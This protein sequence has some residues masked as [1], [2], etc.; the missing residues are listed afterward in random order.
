MIRT[1]GHKTGFA[2]LAAL[3]A[4]TA[5]ADGVQALSYEA[6]GAVGDG[7]AD[8]RPAIIATHAAANKRGLPVRAKDGATYYMGCNGGTAVVRTD[9]DFGTAKFIIDDSHVEK[10]HIR[11]PA[12]SIVPDV[13]PFAVTGLTQ[14][15]KGQA[16]L[17]LSLPTRCLVVL[18]DSGTMRFIRYGRNQNNGSPQQEVVLVERDGQISPET[19]VVWDYAR[20]TS[21]VAHPIGERT[22]VMKGGTFTTIANQAESKYTYYARGIDVRRSN[23][24]IEGF[25]H[26]VTGELDHG[27]PYS[28]FLSFDTC[29]DVTVTGCVFTARRTY[30]TIGSAGKPVSM[31]SYG[32]SVTRGV[33]V[34]FLGCR[35]TTDILDRRYWGLFG[36]NLCRNLLF[37]GCEF[38]RFDAH[39]GVANATIR[40]STL[41]YMGIQAIGFGT[42]R[43]ENCTVRSHGA[44]VSLRSDYGSSWDGD[45]VI[46]NCKYL[47]S[48]RPSIA[49]PPILNGYNAPLHDFGYACTM[50]RRL[51]IDGLFIDDANRSGARG[52][53]YVFGPFDRPC[54]GEGVHPYPITEELVLRNVRTASGRP[55]KISRNKTLFENV[56]VVRE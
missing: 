12:F 55:V 31:G 36:S 14:V 46:R 22:L 38:S 2:A 48:S 33:N 16:R 9:V 34:R 5:G 19:P 49:L 50:P 43:V 51:T 41:G 53:A 3:C 39:T 4:L 40:N 54:T 25:R 26:F 52:E 37:D 56:R 17:N 7:K 45:I 44:F 21:A 8:D 35:Q 29:A 13:R 32:I 18:K 6:F 11:T 15:A 47:P 28:G 1:I 24:R 30:E 42:L 20:V 10:Q 27:A 23:V